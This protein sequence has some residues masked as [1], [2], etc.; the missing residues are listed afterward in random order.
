[1]DDFIHF[2]NR[3]TVT[4]PQTTFLNNVL[5]TLP[6][7]LFGAYLN[8][9]KGGYYA[10]GYIPEEFPESSIKWINSTSD[11]SVTVTGWA[12]GNS[13][14]SPASLGPILDTGTPFILLPPEYCEEY[15]SSF[16][17]TL[18]GYHGESGFAYPCNATLP[19]LY[20]QVGD[21][22][23]HI[24]GKQLS[25]APVDDNPG[26]KYFSVSQKPRSC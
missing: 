18:A 20:L 26:C 5:P 25:G 22:T 13:T 3:F 16:P 14:I 6:E 23:A 4:Q 12:I 15:Y 2:N 24:S 19:D 9:G 11:W 7:P 17:F 1:M 10:F 21:Y 8:R